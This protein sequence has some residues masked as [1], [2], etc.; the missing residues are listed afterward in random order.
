MSGEALPEGLDSASA[1]EVVCELGPGLSGETPADTPAEVAGEAV[2][3]AAVGSVASTPDLPLVAA[4]D[5]PPVDWREELAAKMQ[6]YRTR[7]KPR[8]PKYPS[9]QLPFEVHFEKPAASEPIAWSSL[10][11]EPPPVQLL[12]FD[13]PLFDVPKLDGP[14]L[15]L[16]S[17]PLSAK[18]L[19]SV[20]EVPPLSN[21]I[22]FPR[23][24][25][26][27]LGDELAE[28]L[29]EQPRILEAPEAVPAG[30]ALGGI[31]LEAPEDSNAGIVT[32]AL[33]QPASIGRRFAAAALDMIVVALASGL[34]GWI[35][36]KMVHEA[37]PRPPLLVS[38]AVVMAALWLGY[39]YLLL[40]WSGTTFGLSICGLEL[41][42]LDGSV[43]K[44][45]QRRL[46]L[47][48]SCLSAASLMLGYAWVELDENQ[49]CWHDRITRTYLRV[50]VR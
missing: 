10:A 33:I 39:Q 36:T 30:P 8:A 47:L 34:F 12:D 40:A 14:Q 1:G 15:V 24:G 32:E 44:R 4:V 29:I 31:L 19:P 46:R 37:P 9:L 22:E 45:R 38:G 27:V 41:A 11:L 21:V 43:P 6:E 3:G 26:M 7:R 49:L 18:E 16:A 13:G 17:T 28:P 48:A 42:S 50:R 35:F 2:C 23:Y 5:E 25:E 20:I